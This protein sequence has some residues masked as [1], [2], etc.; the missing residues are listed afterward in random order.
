[1][2]RTAEDLQLLFAA[3]AGYDP[4]DPASSPIPFDDLD[5]EPVRKLRIGYYEED[6]E[7][8]PTPATA[9]TVR[10]AAAA[11]RDAGFDVEPFFPQ[12]LSKAR[13]LWFAIFVQASAILLDLMVQGHEDEINQNTHDVL[14]LAASCQALTGS[15]LL[16]TLLERDE[17]RLQMQAQMQ[18]FPVLLAPVCSIPAFPHGDGGWGAN[19]V[20][21]YLRTMT[22]CQ[23]YNLLGNPAVT[24]PV[25]QS[26]EGL[27]IGVQIIGRPYK[28]NTVLEIAKVL[29]EQFKWREP[30]LAAATP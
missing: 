8:L 28:D 25:G 7:T 21:D 19:H 26:P 11:L 2:A 24:V 23:H 12:G 5:G 16:H 3:T 13:E 14:A 4:R 9:A 17:L 10:T 15:R 22:Y 20:V 29:N 1:M 6:G 18:D 27:P 30:P